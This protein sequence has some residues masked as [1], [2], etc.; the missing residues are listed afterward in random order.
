M[1]SF[2]EA[3]L[4]GIDIG[5]RQLD[6]LQLRI[7]QVIRLGIAVDQSEQDMRRIVLPRLGQFG[8]LL[9]GL[10]E[11][12]RHR[13]DYSI[14]GCLSTWPRSVGGLI[15]LKKFSFGRP[16]LALPIRHILSN[17]IFCFCER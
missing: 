7:T 6:L 8:D 14:G 11:Q 15:A 13:A 12:F 2:S 3:K 4:P 10:A 9:Q 1:I 16:P 17:A 5:N